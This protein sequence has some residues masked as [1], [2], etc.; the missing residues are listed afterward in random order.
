MGQLPQDT[1]KARLQALRVSFLASLP[2]RVAGLRHADP[3]SPSGLGE[4][5]DAAHQLS[6]TAPMFGLAEIGHVAAEIEALADTLL[7]GTGTLGTPASRRL[8]DLLQQLDQEAGRALA[9]RVD[10]T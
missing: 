1:A 4:L 3:A 6:G 7:A 10:G 8:Q 5:R 9:A 2:D